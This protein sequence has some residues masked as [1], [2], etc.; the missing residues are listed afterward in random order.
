MHQIGRANINGS[1]AKNDFVSGCGSGIA[2]EGKYI[3]FTAASGTAIGRAKID[4]TDVNPNFITGLNGTIAFLAA[5][6][7]YIF[8]ADWGDQGSGTTIGRANLDGTDPNQSFI[9]STK[10]GFGIAVTGGN[11]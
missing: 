10:G 8:W 11:P 4:G 1:G 6:S 3:Y 9:T 7:K 2:V 5:D